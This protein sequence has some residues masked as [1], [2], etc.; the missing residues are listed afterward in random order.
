MTPTRHFVVA[1]SPELAAESALRVA[2]ALASA[3]HARLTLFPLSDHVALGAGVAG[4]EISRFAE[5]VQADLLV[6]PRMMLAGEQLSDA[7][8]RRSRVPC[9]VVSPGQED[10]D[11]WLVALDGSPRCTLVLSMVAPLVKAVGGTAKP[12]TVRH[13]DV[14]TEVLREREAL[15]ADV[16]AIG[17][18]PGGPP[19]PIPPGSLARRFVNDAPCMVLTV[20][21]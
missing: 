7:V 10:L 18:R 2:R 11:R 6:L 5:S 8:A 15:Q 19:P 3:T 14:M 4:I 9:L 16:L 13:G 12:V 21:L 20:P 17:L 1:V